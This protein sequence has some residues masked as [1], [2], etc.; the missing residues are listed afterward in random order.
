MKRVVILSAF[1]TPFRSGAEACAEEVAARLKDRFDVTIVT[2]RLRSD[3]P[4]ND[5]LHGVN[6]I[7]VGL[8]M[9]FDKWLYPFLAPFAAKKLQPET[10]HAILETFA[11]LALRLCSMIVPNAKR[12]LT[13]Q[14]TNRN[15]LRRSVLRSPHVV[16]AISGALSLIAAEHGRS[17]VKVIPNGIPLAEI[18]TAMG[19]T[20]REVGRILFAGRL[21][22]MKGVDVLLTAFKQLITRN[23]TLENVHL[24]IVGDG[25]EHANLEKL[26]AELGLSDRVTFLGYLDTTSL[27]REYAEAEIFCGLSRSEALGNVFL[28]AQAAGCAIVATNVGGIPEI[29]LDGKTGILVPADDVDA[30]AVA[31]EKLLTDHALRHSFSNHAAKQAEDYDWDDI[32]NRYAAL[33]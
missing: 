21:K 11:G 27:F 25:S 4:K 1:L 10:I 8:G 3:L 19:G 6:V 29:V 18:H 14:T 15:F 9:S 24:R 12:I 31:L 22:K 26:T 32:A 2:A 28:E 7:R 23:P 13:M 16:T 30:A 17:D 33:Y 20:E 5:T